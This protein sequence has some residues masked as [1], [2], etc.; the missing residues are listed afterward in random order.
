MRSKSSNPVV[1]EHFANA[2][3]A[4]VLVSILASSDSVESEGRQMKQYSGQD[5][6]RDPAMNRNQPNFQYGQYGQH[7]QDNRAF[8]TA[9]T[10]HQYRG[11][12][13]ASSVSSRGLPSFEFGQSTGS[14]GS[15]RGG[16]YLGYRGGFRGGFGN[17]GS[18]SRRAGSR[19]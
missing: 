13:Y 15:G 8:S 18:P 4:T 2:K 19:F 7:R 17:R 5:R 12:G 1:R 6:T 3:V 14:G 16:G 10:S 9:S 11:R